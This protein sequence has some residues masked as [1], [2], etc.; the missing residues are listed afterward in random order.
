MED[1]EEHE[2]PHVE[3]QQ[4]SDAEEHPAPGPPA[5][6]AADPAAAAEPAAGPPAEPAAAD[7][8]NRRRHVVHVSPR[9][10]YTP[11]VLQR[12]APPGMTFGLD[13]KAHRFTVKF[14][15]KPRD[16]Q[17]WASYGTGGSRSK[18]FQSMP[19]QDALKELHQEA[20]ERWDLAKDQPGF[21]L[22]SDLRQT[23]G[24]VSESMLDLLKGVMDAM[25]PP[26]K[27]PKR[28]A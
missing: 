12:L 28:A 27:Y 24:H 18:A 9:E 25:P 4:V 23:P 13:Q 10:H 11:A 8:A 1:H 3:L 17:L 15:V 2:S 5:D 22:E 14:K 21:E 7:A 20:W 26:T 16:A 6:P 19:W